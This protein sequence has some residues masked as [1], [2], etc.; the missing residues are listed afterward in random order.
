[1]GPWSDRISALL[2]GD[3]RELAPL[4]MHA[5]KIGHVSTQ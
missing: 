2:R 4:P 3:Y 5:Q 1:M